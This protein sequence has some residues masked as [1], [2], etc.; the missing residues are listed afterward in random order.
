MGTT[1]RD[2]RPQRRL[3]AG[4]IQWRAVRLAF[5]ALAVGVLLGLLAPRLLAADEPGAGVRNEH[6]VAPGESLWELAH[7]YG[8]GDPRRFVHEVA[9]L[10][11]LSDSL[12]FPGQRLVLP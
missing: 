11:D 7:R 4:R 6:R 10:N 8:Q 5:V 3:K 12:I 2:I 9:N 1:V